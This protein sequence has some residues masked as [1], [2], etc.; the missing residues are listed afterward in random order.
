M[1]TVVVLRVLFKRAAVVCCLVLPFFS[2]ASEQDLSQTVDNTTPIQQSYRLTAVSFR[3]ENDAVAGTDENYSNGISLA[4]SREGKG[5]P[6][7]V[8]DTVGLKDPAGEYFLSYEIG[9]IIITPS[10]TRRVP[11]DP[12]DRPYAGLLYI[13]L[14]TQWRTDHDF[15]GLKFV[16]GVVGPFSLAEE[17]QRWFHRLIGNDVPKGWDYQLKNEPILNLVYEFRHSIRAK[18]AVVGP[19]LELIPVFNLMA[20]NVLVQG[21]MGLQIR[22]GYNIP[23]DFGSSQIRGFGNLPLPSAH[24]LRNSQARWGVY[25]FISLGGAVVG[26][27]VTLDGNTFCEGPHVSKKPGYGISE[28]G[29]SAWVNHLQLTASLVYWTKE[30]ETQKHESKFGTLTVTV[31]F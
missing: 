21:Q 26:R 20:G 2:E 12:K 29:I 4:A 14:S 27:N 28:V 24:C 17:T 23:R 8:W 22:A 3:W 16:T 13:A 9:Q 19:N 7:L 31:Y 25:A 1:P 10:D 30:F 11:P 5:L 6:G 15:H 18:E